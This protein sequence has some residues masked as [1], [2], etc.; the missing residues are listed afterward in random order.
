ML[1]QKNKPKYLT[2]LLTI[3]F[4]GSCSSETALQT[5][6]KKC[7]QE[8]LL[9]GLLFTNAVAGDREIGYAICFFFVKRY[10]EDACYSKNSSSRS[11]TSRRTGTSSSSRGSSSGGSSS[12]A[13]GGHGGGGGSIEPKKMQDFL[14]YIEQSGIQIP[15][16]IPQETEK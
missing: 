13:G 15:E 7:E 11:S 3:L 10:C 12:S 5:C 6:F 16:N 14:N 9:C 8:S 1:V 2:I 4:I